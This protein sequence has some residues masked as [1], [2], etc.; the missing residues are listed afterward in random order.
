VRFVPTPTTRAGLRLRLFGFFNIDG[1][2]EKKELTLL[3][4]CE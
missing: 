4:G 1:V 2:Q 3:N